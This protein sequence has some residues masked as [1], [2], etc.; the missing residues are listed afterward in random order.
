VGKKER[1]TH[2][3]IGSERGHR[4]I[5]SEREETQRDR[6]VSGD[7]ERLEGHRLRSRGHTFS[8]DELYH[9]FADQ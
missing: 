3:E 4:E 1:N 2:R 6:G 7:T 9:I 8:C 5:R